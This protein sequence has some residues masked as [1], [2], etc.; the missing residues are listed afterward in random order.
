MV[1]VSKRKLE[2]DTVLVEGDMGADVED[3]EGDMGA[4]VEDV[5]GDMMPDVED[6]EGG[7][8]LDVE[9]DMVQGNMVPRGSDEESELSL[10]GLE[11][12]IDMR[13]RAVEEEGGMD[14]EVGGIDSGDC[15]EKNRPRVEEVEIGVESE[16]EGCSEEERDRIL[17]KLRE[18][19]QKCGKEGDGIGRFVSCGIVML[20]QTGPSLQ[21]HD[22]P[23]SWTQYYSVLSFLLNGK[24]HAEYVRMSGM[25]GLP[26]C[27]STQWG[28]IVK[29]LEPH[30]TALAEWSWL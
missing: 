20:Q 22:C 14:M 7:M 18:V 9:G 1:M 27:S 13:P 28:R 6:V 19:A 12:R 8:V 15:S 2:G 5:E 30:V 26:K 11:E 21:I 23:R 3:V 10:N 16:R 25:L 17:E 24:L 4:D 29:W